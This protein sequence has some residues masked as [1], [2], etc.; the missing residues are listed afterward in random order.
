[1]QMPEGVDSSSNGDVTKARNP[2]GYLF[3]RASVGTECHKSV[4]I[5]RSNRGKYEQKE[6]TQPSAMSRRLA[7]NNLHA[8]T[9]FSRV[10]LT[11]GTLR[12]VFFTS[13]LAK[14]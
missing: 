13:G 9:R 5:F 14:A 4:I 8:T 11:A 6:S 3:A 1:M 12:E 7:A 10:D 2:C